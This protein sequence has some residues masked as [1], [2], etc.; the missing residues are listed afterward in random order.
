M[1]REL[2]VVEVRARIDAQKWR[3]IAEYLAD[4]LSAL[5]RAT[6]VESSEEGDKMWWA[7]DEAIRAYNELVQEENEE[8]VSHG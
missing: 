2:S 4:A 3:E 1:E 6:G 8:E 5:T 7:A